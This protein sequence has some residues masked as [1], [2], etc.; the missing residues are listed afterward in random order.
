[1]FW[2]RDIIKALPIKMVAFNFTGDYSLMGLIFRVEKTYSQPRVTVISEQEGQRPKIIGSFGKKNPPEALLDKMTEEE[3][4]EYLNYINGLA[5]AKQMF[6]VEADELERIFIKVAPQF[7]KAIFELW[8]LAKKYDLPFSPVKEML[9]AVLN[10]GKDIE[11]KVNK[12]SGKK[13]N[14]L[15][16]YGINISEHNEPNVD[17]ESKKLFQALLDTGKETKIIARD[18][19]EIASSVYGKKTNFEPHF[20]AF[21]ADP[22]NTKRLQGWFYTI[23][24][25]LLKKYGV[26]PLNILSASKIA[27]HWA[28]LQVERFSLEKA[29]QIF[30]KEFKPPKDQQQNC[31][32]A[33]SK[34]YLIYKEIKAQ[35]KKGK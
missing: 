18:F 11:D 20:F 17:L 3:Q 33:I 13:T 10:K 21:Y 7:N 26:N 30:V 2:P 1:M 12:I 4:Y 23:A 27:K 8:K 28:R 16:K 9:Y 29:K 25:D 6:N 35:H 19:K 24:I 31:F 15:E 14:I 34:T 22:K 32:E 5:F